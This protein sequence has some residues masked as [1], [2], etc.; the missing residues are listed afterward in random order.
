MTTGR[1]LSPEERESLWAQ[2]IILMFETAPLT[3]HFEQMMLTPFQLKAVVSY[4]QMIMPK[5]PRGGFGVMTNDDFAVTLPNIPIC[6]TEEECT[7][8]A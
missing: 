8:S 3:D 4:V 7:K 2:K 1:P 5:E 6:Y